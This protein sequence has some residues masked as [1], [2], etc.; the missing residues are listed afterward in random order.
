VAKQKKGEPAMPGDILGLSDD[1]SNVK[2]PHPPS[3]GSVP[4]GI[5]VRHESSRHWGTEDLERSKGA[6]GVDMGAGGEG[7][8]VAPEPRRTTPADEV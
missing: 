5:E 2:L 1:R 7:T 4:S 3:D 8:D 6:V